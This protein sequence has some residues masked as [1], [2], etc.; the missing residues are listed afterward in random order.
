ME[1]E[2]GLDD[3]DICAQAMVAIIFFLC[4]TARKLFQAKA[5]SGLLHANGRL[6]ALLFTAGVITDWLGGFTK[7]KKKVPEPKAA[8]LSL[9]TIRV[10]HMG[11]L[12]SR[13]VVAIVV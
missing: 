13:A 1:R 11:R 8:M 9:G 6:T 2:R 7:Q 3:K 12:R 4:A 10:R 5:F